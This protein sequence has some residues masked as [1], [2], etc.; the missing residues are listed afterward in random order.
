MADPAA[1]LRR[2]VDALVQTQITT[3]NQA[4][5]LTEL[6][7]VRA[8]PERARALFAIDLREPEEPVRKKIAFP[9]PSV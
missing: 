5:L 7:D 1:V 3:L 4:K 2:V 9:C 6:A 8:R